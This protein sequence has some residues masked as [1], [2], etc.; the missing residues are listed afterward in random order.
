MKKF[1]IAALMI[2]GAGGLVLLSSQAVD[3]FG[4]R[5][6]NGEK[7]P[8]FEQML[9]EKAEIL[10][11]TVDELKAK[12]ETMTLREIAEE[13]GLD[14]EQFREAK[15]VQMLERW[16]EMGLTDEEIAERQQRMEDRQKSCDEGEP[17]E[18]FGKRGFG[19]RGMQR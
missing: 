17:H 9:E 11:L 4:A 15:K 12:M 16:Q 5:N 2:V 8:H 7:P 14:I 19:R 3:A 1:L 10:G 6:F 13:E 18:H